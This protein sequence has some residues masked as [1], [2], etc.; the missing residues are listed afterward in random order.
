LRGLELSEKTTKNIHFCLNSKL[1]FLG[2]TFHLIKPYKVNWLIKNIK[3]KTE[4]FL[5]PSKNSTRKFRQAIK[6]VTSMKY[7]NL[8]YSDIV[9]RL[10]SIINNWGTYFIFSSNQYVLRGHLDFFVHKRFMKWC[11]KKYGK[12]S[13]IFYNMNKEKW[14]KSDK[15]RS[16]S[17]DRVFYIKKLRNLSTFN[18]FPKN[19]S[20]E[21]FDTLSMYINPQFYIM[22]VLRRIDFKRNIL[23]HC[24]FLQEFKCVFCQKSLFDFDQFSNFSKLG[25]EFIFLDSI[26]NKKDYLN[27]LITRSILVN[28]HRSF[29]Y[30]GVQ[31]SSIIPKILIKGVANFRLLDSIFNKVVMHLHCYQNKIKIDYRYLFKSWGKLRKVSQGSN[32][33]ITKDFLCNRFFV[34]EY[35]DQLQ[36]F[37]DKKYMKKIFFIFKCINNYNI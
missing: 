34:K 1:D 21:F 23:T 2:W 32:F 12:K 22:W 17:V 11:Y 30:S 29:W 10:N 8:N 25:Q 28:S 14:R 35:L 9:S 19:I 7:V 24:M 33:K 20:S 13:Y 18:V 37:F 16:F 15:V 36:K 3:K 27:D 5:Y 4:L 6:E 26:T 31:F